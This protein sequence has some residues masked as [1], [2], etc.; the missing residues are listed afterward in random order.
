MTATF[1]SHLL[2]LIQS[3]IM[4]WIINMFVFCVFFLMGS[5]NQNLWEPL[6]T[7]FLPLSLKWCKITVWP[8]KLFNSINH[9][10]YK[11]QA[12]PENIIGFLISMLLVFLYSF[13]KSRGQHRASVRSGSTAHL[14]CTFEHIRPND[15]HRSCDEA[16]RRQI[17]EVLF[18]LQGLY[19]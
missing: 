9:I 12:L 5:M 4:N 16:G 18:S 8:I 13:V 14:L 11:P 3:Q 6:T 7:F 15:A 10:A 2:I 19:C 17:A 1:C